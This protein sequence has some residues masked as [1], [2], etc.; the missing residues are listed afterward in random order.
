MEY[1]MQT[2]SIQIQ[3]NYVNDFMN[4]VDN[5]SQNITIA[6]DKNLEIDSYF[7][8]RRKK[9]HQIRNDVKNGKMKLLT[10]EES[11]TEIELF[12]QELENN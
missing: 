4:Y 11:D 1:I 9:L 5:H 12:F 6:K 10:Q 7:Y 3:D 8:D 2:I